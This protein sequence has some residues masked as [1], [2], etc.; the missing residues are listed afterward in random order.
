MGANPLTRAAGVAGARIW[1][2]HGKSVSSCAATEFPGVDIEPSVHGPAASG[3]ALDDQ[4]GSECG[5]E[6]LCV[7]PREKGLRLAETVVSFS[8]LS[9]V[10]HATVAERCGKRG[11]LCWA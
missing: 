8:D 7:P 10:G 6:S 2:D 11:R 4:Y 9:C 5:C 3:P 1:W